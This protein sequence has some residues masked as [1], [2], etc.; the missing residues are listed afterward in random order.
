MG[1]RGV[2][3]VS[4]SGGSVVPS[5]V[6]GF[7]GVEGEPEDEECGGSW[8]ALSEFTRGSQLASQE[9]QAVSAS[10]NPPCIASRELQ[11]TYAG[12]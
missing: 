4:I 9:Q 2:L 5:S 8:E 12:G 3:S 10:T 1:S 11:S 6:C 7:M